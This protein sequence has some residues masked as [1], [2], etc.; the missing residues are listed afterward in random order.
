MPQNTTQRPLTANQ[1][2]VLTALLDGH[3]VAGAAKQAGVD[4]TAVYRWL[5]E[6]GGRFTAALQDASAAM[7]QGTTAQLAG[8]TGAAVLVLAMTM[9]D[10]SERGASTRVRAAEAVLS[11]AARLA[12]LV[13]LESRI[14]ALEG[15]Q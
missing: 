5:R 3:N 15:A 10:G 2:K 13:A 6:P 7:L 1:K 12:E 14:R 11:H 9:K 4:R 8:L